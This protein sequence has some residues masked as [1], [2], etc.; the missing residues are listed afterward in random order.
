MPPWEKYQ[1]SGAGP[2]AKYAPPMTRAQGV[3]SAWQDVKALPGKAL[4]AVVDEVK[5]IAGDFAKGVSHE[6][7]TKGL[8]ETPQASLLPNPLKALPGAPVDLAKGAYR[9]AT[10]APTMAAKGVGQVGSAATG[11]L[12]KPDEI[13]S[14]L[15]V[16]MPGRIRQIPGRQAPAPTTDQIEA[17]AN[18]AYANA[19]GLGV[20]LHQGPV[21]RLADDIHSELENAGFRERN[22]PN[23]WRDIGEL[24]NPASRFTNISD[25]ESVRKVLNRTRRN[26]NNP[27]EQEAAAT[28]IERIDEFLENLTPA[29]ASNNAHLAPRVAQQFEEARA[30]WGAFR[31]SERLDDLVNVVQHRTQS[32]G[33]GGNFNNVMRQ[34]I[35]KILDSPKQRQGFNQAELDQMERIVNGTAGANA[36]RK[37]GMFSS[38]GAVSTGIGAGVGAG[39][40][41]ALGGPPGA[42]VGSVAVPALSGGA[43]LLADRSTGNQLERL[44]EMV[45][46]RAPIAQNQ[47]APSRPSDIDAFLRRFYPIAAL[48]GQQAQQ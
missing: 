14:A 4:G 5:S 45:R 10:L 24:H 34:E 11:G 20:E 1:D 21:S 29:H 47:Q 31:R 12:L 30:N 43:K 3:S 40:G 9:T 41:A 17:A 37:F 2:W 18:Q 32:T 38:H 39:I 19:R 6:E 35:R 25:V 48:G 27:A 15:S 8:G 36:L 33:K 23:A 28:A 7:I 44:R 46:R 13:E 22:V 16:A 42:A 26:P